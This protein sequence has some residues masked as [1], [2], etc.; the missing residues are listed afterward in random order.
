MSGSACPPGGGPIR[1]VPRSNPF[2][3][4][5]R[6]GF[7]MDGGRWTVD[8]GDT[9]RPPS[10]AHSPTGGRDIV[11]RYKPR[12]I[13]AKWQARWAADRLYEAVERP[14]RPKWYALTMFPYTSGRT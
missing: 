14:D 6:R 7:F 5:G 3:P 2:V 11:E 8:G 13:E 1:V 9:R 4:G 12:E 10:T